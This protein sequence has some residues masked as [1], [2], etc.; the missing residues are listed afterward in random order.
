MG[1]AKFV[2]KNCNYNFEAENPDECKFCGMDCI[3]KQKSAIELL[4][5]I[6]GLLRG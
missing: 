1:L 2:C 5:E 4:E 3:E 6:E